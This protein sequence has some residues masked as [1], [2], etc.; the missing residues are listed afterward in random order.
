SEP[1]GRVPRQG[2]GPRMIRFA[3]VTKAFGD[4]PT[5]VCAVNEFSLEVPRGEFCSVMGPSGSGKSTLLH[6]VAGFTPITKG[7]VYLDGRPISGIDRETM[8][9]LRR[10][11][12]GFIFQF[13][14][15]LPYLSAERNVAL[16]LVVDGQPRS[17]IEE[18]TER[19]L[20]L[21]G[22]LDRRGH[23]PG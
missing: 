19:A 11:E 9:Q 14:N 15:L 5:R 2:V 22:L 7:E 1:R 13:F 12:I 8:A 4:G 6:L 3:K 10:R 17:V 16:P 21:V 18:R 23:K 20:R